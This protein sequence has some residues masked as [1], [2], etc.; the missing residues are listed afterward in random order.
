MSTEINA[1]DTYGHKICHDSML[2]KLYILQ[3]NTN[4]KKKNYLP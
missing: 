2:Y 1:L 3:N 4:K